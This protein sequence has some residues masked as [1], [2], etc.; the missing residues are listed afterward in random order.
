MDP[1]E[2]PQYKSPIVYLP[3][4][5]VRELI[6]ER[7]TRAKAEL[8]PEKYEAFKKAWAEDGGT[9]PDGF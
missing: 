3:Q 8:S 4:Q 7:F 2:I 6:L 5:R 1:N 9:V